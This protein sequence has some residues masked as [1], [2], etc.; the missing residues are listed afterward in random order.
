MYI[1]NRLSCRRLQDLHNTAK[2][3]NTQTLQ[4]LFDIAFKMRSINP[5]YNLTLEVLDNHKSVL[6]SYRI[7][8]SDYELDLL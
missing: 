6:T 5:A 7:E 8:T 1:V 4:S 3:S 2:T